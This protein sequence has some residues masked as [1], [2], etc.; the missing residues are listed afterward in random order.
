MLVLVF[1]IFLVLLVLGGAIF[2]A[3]GGM[4]L[5]EDQL[6]VKT[7]V[8]GFLLLYAV[9][10]VGLKLV[11][12]IIPANQVDAGSLIPDTFSELSSSIEIPAWPWEISTA[13]GAQ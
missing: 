13:L 3:K 12:P 2:I 7:L 8:G 9:A 11:L 6:M 4:D 5:C 1:S 10:A